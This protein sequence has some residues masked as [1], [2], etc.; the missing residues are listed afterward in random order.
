MSQLSVA[1]LSKDR[2]IA[3]AYLPGVDSN[4]DVADNAVRVM[5]SCESGTVSTIRIFA[6]LA[7]CMLDRNRQ[8]LPTQELT[9]P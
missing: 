5:D 2:L 3:R 6:I 1:H 7:E 4:W 8:S 9:A